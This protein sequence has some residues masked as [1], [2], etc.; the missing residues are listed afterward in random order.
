MLGSRFLEALPAQ[1]TV[2]PREDSDIKKTNELFEKITQLK[3]DIIL[4]CAADTN[5]EGAE[6]NPSLAL[7]VNALLPSLLAQAARKIEALLVHFS[8]TG[9]YGI[10]ELNPWAPHSDFETPNPT[11][12]H[13]K[14]KIYGED[15]IK[16]VGCR[17]LILRLGWLYGGSI[18]HKKNFVWA[19]IQE[20]RIKQELQSDPYQIGSPTHVDDV[21]KQTLHILEHNLTGVYNVVAHG[22]ASRF[23]Y[24]SKILSSAHLEVKLKPL[25]F[26]RK[27]K[28]SFNEAAFN[29]KLAFMGL[30]IMPLWEEAL[31]TYVQTLLK[32][33]QK[34]K[35]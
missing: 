18:H 19:R 31:E 28:V 13:H 3:P 34:T 29:E 25:R 4:N 10:N 8:S 17:A 14:S 20:G 7:S 2:F 16:D 12:A 35:L 6:D 23:D 11:T 5:V 15:L 22:A 30:D 33:E 26:I 9:C 24:V 21:V 32:E 27:A 1:I